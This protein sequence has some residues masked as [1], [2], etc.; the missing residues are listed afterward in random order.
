METSKRKH[1]TKLKIQFEQRKKKNLRGGKTQKTLENIKTIMSTQGFE[2][3][4]ISN[5][6][7][8]ISTVRVIN[9]RYVY[10]FFFRQ[11]KNSRKS[12]SNWN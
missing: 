7:K 12:S 9:E 1:K 5:E 6:R 10:C 4:W 2:S 8:S 11:S 3:R